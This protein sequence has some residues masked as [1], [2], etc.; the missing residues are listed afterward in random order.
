MNVVSRRFVC[1]NDS[2]VNDIQIACKLAI[3]MLIYF[4][5]VVHKFIFVL[6]GHGSNVENISYKLNG[7]IV[8]HRYYLYLVFNIM[9]NILFDIYG[10]QN[11]LNKMH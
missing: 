10:L 5:P 6:L 9:F 2:L 8:K 7:K 3:M 4:V 1:L 11:P